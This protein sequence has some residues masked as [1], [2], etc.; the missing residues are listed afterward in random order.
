MIPGRFDE[1]ARM[2]IPPSI[3]LLEKWG[4]TG[5]GIML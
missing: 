3:T 5:R 4:K 2:A 1:P